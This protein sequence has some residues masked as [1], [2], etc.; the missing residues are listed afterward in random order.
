MRAVQVSPC[1]IEAAAEAGNR[2][3]RRG[4][5]VVAQSWKVEVVYGTH[6]NGEKEGCVE[7][8]GYVKGVREIFR[9]GDHDKSPVRLHEQILPR[10]PGQP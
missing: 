10:L 5:L 1:R 7:D 2:Q 3:D 9:K 6:F 8:T 4:L